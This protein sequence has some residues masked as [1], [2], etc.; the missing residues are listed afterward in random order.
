MIDIKN[1]YLTLIEPNIQ[2]III[3]GFFS[4][5]VIQKLDTMTLLLFLVILFVIVYFIC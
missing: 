2:L 1:I 4:L 3:I 5:L